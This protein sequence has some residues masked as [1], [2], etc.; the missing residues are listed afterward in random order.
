MSRPGQGGEF[1]IFVLMA[2]N[3]NDPQ[4]IASMEL[5][6]KDFYDTTGKLFGRSYN[7]V[8]VIILTKFTTEI[9]LMCHGNYPNMILKTRSLIIENVKEWIS[10]PEYQSVRSYVDNTMNKM[11]GV[12][13]ATQ[14]SSGQETSL[15]HREQT[16]SSTQNT[17]TRGTTGNEPVFPVFLD[18]VRTL[19]H[20]REQINRLE[21]ISQ[22]RMP[23]QVNS[24]PDSLSGR[25]TKI[26]ELGNAINI[27]IEQ[28]SNI[29]F[30]KDAILANQTS[31]N[32]TTGLETSI[33]SLND[34]N[35]SQS[36]S[37][38][39]DPLTAAA[40]S[41]VRPSIT[42]GAESLNRW[43]SISQHGLR[44]IAST[45][46]DVMLRQMRLL[47]WQ[48][49]SITDRHR[50]LI[51]I[52][53]RARNLAA[54]AID[55]GHYDKALELLE[56]GRS[57]VWTQILQ[58]RTPV[59]DLREVDPDLADRFIKISQLL[60]RRPPERSGIG[61][62]GLSLARNGDM[63]QPSA[64]EV[65]ESQRY[66]ALAAEWE[67]ITEQARSLPGFEDF[68]KPP[69]FSKLLGAARGGPVVVLNIDDKRCD[70]LVILPEFE[71]II[72][73]PLPNITSK[74]VTEL[75]DELKDLLS[76]SGIRQRAAKRVEEE[77]D[78]EEDCSYILAELWNGIVKPVLDLL[79]IPVGLSH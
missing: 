12:A 45:A 14:G 67:W 5:N 73:I 7:H 66:R 76:T 51:Q 8:Y 42:H 59:D 19:L 46:Y 60:A 69:T 1:S 75:R 11:L 2:G 63:Q 6:E 54:S 33:Y 58:L 44:G 77:N 37:R 18:R 30:I 38:P 55:S 15:R 21:S 9:P 50:Y 47:T 41:L 25:F 24:P 16:T 65:E 43:I 72:H 79:A 52:G 23:A 70:A 57:I 28:L 68:L 29:P 78:R 39:M 36:R 4:L 34:R 49:I 56:Q 13:E 17:A 62:G 20:G 61:V 71:E 64:E 10:S 3:Q 22:W 35:A 48:G 32:I 26:N 31:V 74:R 27:Q 53:G 40:W